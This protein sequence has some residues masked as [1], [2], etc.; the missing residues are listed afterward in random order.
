VSAHDFE[1]VSATR[2]DDLENRSGILRQTL[3]WQSP[4]SAEFG[5]A[6]AGDLREEPQPEQLFGR[7]RL[8]VDYDAE[9]DSLSDDELRLVQDAAETAGS[10]G[11]RYAVIFPARDLSETGGLWRSTARETALSQLGPGD[12]RH[13]GIEAISYLTLTS[14]LVYLEA[15]PHLSWY[16]ANYLA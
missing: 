8:F 7:V 10:S 12:W 1:Q 9:R 4:A 11:Y 13:L 5:S 15:A 3:L 2:V 6:G 16:V 14:T